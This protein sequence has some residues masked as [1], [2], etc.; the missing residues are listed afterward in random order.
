METTPLLITSAPPPRGPYALATKTPDDRGATFTWLLLGTA[1]GS[2]DA[3]RQLFD[4]A[5]P[6]IFGVARRVLQDSHQAEEVCQEVL[7]EIWRRSPLFDPT[8]GSALSWIMTLSHSRAVD[9]VR[10]SQK[11]RLRDTRY[12]VSSLVRDH[13]SVSE[14]FADSVERAEVAA[15]LHRLT[16]LQ[17]EVIDLAYFQGL[18][19]TQI[20]AT[21]GVPAATVKTR[22]RSALIKLRQEFAAAA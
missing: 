2:T 9:R 13:D 20:A 18:T 17:R 1:A 21:L 14:E 4:L 22:I 8:K 5:G 10:Q 7:V 15:S 11:S 3:F 6:A 12:T 16:D 19:S